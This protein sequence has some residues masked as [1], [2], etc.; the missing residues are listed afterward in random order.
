MTLA[1]FK[2]MKPK[3]RR[4]LVLAF[5][6]LVCLFIGA[7][8]LLSMLFSFFGRMMNTH[9]LEDVNAANILEKASMNKIIT[10]LGQSDTEQ[11]LVIDCSGRFHKDELTGRGVLTAFEMHVIDLGDKKNAVTWKIEANEKKA[12]VLREREENSNLSSLSMRKLTFKDYYPAL[13]R[14]TA[15][16]LMTTLEDTF[17]ECADGGAYQ[18]AGTFDN[19][20][21]PAFSPYIADGLHGFWVSMLEAISEFGETFRFNSGACVPLLLSTEAVDEE[22]S[23]NKKTVLLQPELACVLLMECGVYSY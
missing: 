10:A 18:F 12:T 19:D 8:F 20:K 7:L 15:Q 11:L 13:S 21:E 23:T 6:V 1:Q 16:N 17:P 22:H 4:R 2:R 5:V 9:T 3:Y 14:I